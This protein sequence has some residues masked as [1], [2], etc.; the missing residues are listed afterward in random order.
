MLTPNN[1]AAAGLDP[2]HPDIF[3]IKKG[4]EEADGIAS[5]TNTGHQKIRQSLLALE[6]LLTC[7]IPDDPVKISHDHRIR[8]SPES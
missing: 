3:V 2:G 5:A 7:L 6:D 1:A 8:M 4:I